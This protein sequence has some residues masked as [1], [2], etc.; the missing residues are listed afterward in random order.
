MQ[1]DQHDTDPRLVELYDLENIRGADTDF[2][3]RL[4]ASVKCGLK[5]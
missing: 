1:L 4:A 2:Y 3:V 5:L